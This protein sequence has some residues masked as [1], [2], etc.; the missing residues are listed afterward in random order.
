MTGHNVAKRWRTRL[1]IAVPGLALVLV[2]F[3]APIIPVD[4]QQSCFGQGPYF[5]FTDWQSPSYYLF[6]IGYDYM[7]YH[8]V[9]PL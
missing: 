8:L 4:L 1:L 3:L 9:C 5:H 6:K 2:F 7:P